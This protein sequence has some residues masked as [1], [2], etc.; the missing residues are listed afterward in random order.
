MTGFKVIIHDHQPD[1]SSYQGPGLLLSYSSVCRHFTYF[2]SHLCI[3][4][5]F[6][7]LSSCFRFTS[8]QSSYCCC[9]NQLWRPQ[10]FSVTL[11][12]PLYTMGK[13]HK[14]KFGGEQQ[15]SRTKTHQVTSLLSTEWYWQDGESRILVRQLWIQIKV[16]KRWQQNLFSFLWAPWRVQEG[17]NRKKP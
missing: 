16:Q 11:C 5:P 12:R 8:D 7:H 1:N 9:W 4:D 17:P 14:V 3:F 2:I 10:R 15:V 13:Q 6:P